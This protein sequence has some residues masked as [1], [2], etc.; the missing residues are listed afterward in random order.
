M[1]RMCARFGGR[2]AFLSAKMLKNL[3]KKILA[4]SGLCIAIPPA[5]AAG[6]L[7][8]G[9]GFNYSS[10]RYGTA[11]TTNITS[12]PFLAKY[13][14]DLWTYKLTVP[15][16]LVSGGTGVIPG[17]GNVANQNPQRRG[18]SGATAATQ[19]LGDVVASATYA[20]YY[21]STSN[22]ELDL[23][24]RV[25]LG[26][27]DR[28][29][30]LGTGENDYAAQVDLYKGL[31]N[32]TVFGGVGCNVLGSS[33]YI[34]LNNVFNY[35]AGSSYKFSDAT[36]VGV[37][38]DARDRVAATAAPISEMTMYVNRTLA[39]NLK[40]QTYVLKG[41]ESGSPNWGLGATVSA[42]F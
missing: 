17:I 37:T 33:S 9:T 6:D 19:G 11:T 39:L 23:T 35:T 3:H 38:Y 16:L 40:A 30:G 20:A 29:K 22:F 41:F 8:I 31:G 13:E 25:K 24:G 4:L 27:A 21:D 28:N 18:P 1:T 2:T 26:T 32:F 14:T 42:T 34:A 15:Y 10:G 36:A 5:L 12:I 7:S